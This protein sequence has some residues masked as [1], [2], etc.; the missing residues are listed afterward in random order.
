MRDNIPPGLSPPVK[1]IQI[2]IAGRVA[3]LQSKTSHKQQWASFACAGIYQE[4]NY[5]F[6]Q[7]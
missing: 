7:L 6:L 4:S 2:V 1:E 5:R 3:I